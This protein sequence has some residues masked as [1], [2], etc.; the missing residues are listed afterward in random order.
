MRHP[1][2]LAS[3]DVERFLS[4]LAVRGKVSAS[5][6]NQAR[7]ALVFFYA[8]VLNRPL[9][10]LGGLPRARRPTR[11]PVVMTRDEVR[12]VLEQLH[13]V[14][15]LMGSLLY[16]SGL[17]L[18]E[19]VSLRI[20]D[21]DLGARQLMVRHAKGQKDRI[22]L[23]AESLGAQ[24]EEHLQRVR[25]QFEAD[26]ARGAGYVALPGA[27]ASKY[28]SAARGWPWQWVFPA[29]RSYVDEASGERRRHQVH[30][31]RCSAP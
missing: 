10:E 18:S 8:E 20:K 1:R 16:G 31:R 11:L 19:C 2:E 28:P 15:L 26:L 5:T 7:A 13:G 3:R 12:R 25:S 30:E 17:R 27:L 22:A 14:W 6:Q 9:A 23:L 21:V 4:D 29:S 24:L